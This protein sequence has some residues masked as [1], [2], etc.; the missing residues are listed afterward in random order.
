M[1]DKIKKLLKGAGFS[2]DVIT[3]A[4]KEDKDFDI[5]Q[6]IESNNEAQKEHY[7]S[8][9]EN[10]IKDEVKDK[11]I[12]ERDGQMMSV[13]NTALKKAGVP[14]AEIET[15]EVKD[16]MK[17]ALEHFKAEAEKAG[18]GVNEDFKKIQEENLKLKNELS[19]KEDWMPKSEFEKERQAL[20][21][22][23]KEEKVESLL[24]K[25]FTGIP[26]NKLLGN[27]HSDGFFIALKN[28]IGTKYDTDIENGEV[29]FYEK[30]TQKKVI[31]KSGGKD[32]FLKAADILNQELKGLSFLVESNGNGGEGQRDQNSGEQGGENAK[33]KSAR[34]LEMENKIKAEQT[35]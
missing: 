10:E 2:D 23:R 35:A 12:K 6:A 32:D 17:V 20:L 18:A 28:V 8:L 29:V 16:K 11:V 5:Q 19:E 33:P 25:Q 27:K 13:I 22:E 15:A 31:G 1:N 34:L 14:M 3:A 9:L 24:H 21:N 4:E 30:G 26:A 7:K